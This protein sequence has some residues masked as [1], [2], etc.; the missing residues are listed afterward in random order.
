[1]GSFPAGVHAAEAIHVKGVS[2]KGRRPSKA[3]ERNPSSLRAFDASVSYGGRVSDFST[4]A[5]EP[6]QTLMVQTFAS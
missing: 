4:N 5:D 6:L 1:M 3:L 2:Q